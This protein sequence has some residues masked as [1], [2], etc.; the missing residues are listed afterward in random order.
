MANWS[1]FHPDPRK[2]YYLF[3]R[4]GYGCAAQMAHARVK[5]IDAMIMG[6]Q[7]SPREATAKSWLANVVY[8]LGATARSRMS[9][10]RLWESVRRTRAAESPKPENQLSSRL[11]QVG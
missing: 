3:L 1:D 9:L 2:S 5:Q 7:D 8:F 6:L 11:S 4:Q 10:T